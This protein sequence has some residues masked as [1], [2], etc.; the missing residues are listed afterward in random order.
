MSEFNFEA[1]RECLHQF[2]FQELF[3]HQL[4]WE[5]PSKIKTIP[6][7]IDDVTFSSKPISHLSGAAIFEIENP[8]GDIPDK[9]IQKRIHHEVTKFYHENLLVFV[10]GTRTQSSW[11][12]MKTDGNKKIYRDHLYMKGQP[13][14]LF[15]SIVSSMFVDISELDEEGHIPILEASKKIANAFDIEKTTKEFYSEYDAER[16]DL[17]E[18]I[19]GIDDEKDRR[20]YASVLLNRLMFIYFLQKKELINDKDMGYLQN[21][22]AESKERGKNQFYSYFLKLLFFEGFAKPE[23]KRSEE[24]NHV[25]GK[26]RYLNG[27]LFL[28]H[29]LE[30]KWTN[31]CIA[32]DAFENI[33]KLFTRYTWN[34]DDRPGGNDNEISPDVL[35]YIFE[36]YINQKA[37]GAY[38]TKPEITEYLCEHTI[39]QVIL[40]KVN[41]PEIPGVLPARCYATMD[42]MLLKADASLC[43]E[44]LFNVLPKL[45]LLDPA[46]G[47]GA[48][49]VAA[50]KTLINIYSAIIGK[51]DFLGDHQ[52]SNWLQKI[53]SE[54]PSV[55]YF[56]K[57]QIITN[58]LFGVD[59]MPEAAEIAKLRLFL[60]LVASVQTVDQLEPLPNIDFNLLAG[61]SLIGLLRVNEEAFNRKQ[62]PDA[63][64]EQRSFIPQFK[65]VNMFQ[66]SYRQLVDEKQRQL[67][68][69]RNTTKYTE[70]LQ[71]LRDEIESN[72]LQTYESL[73][74]LLLN[75]FSRLEI[76]YEQATWDEKTNK[77]G[78]PVKRAVRLGDIE[79]L[80]PFHWGYE[81][82]EVMNTRGGFDAIITNPPWDIFK[83]NGKEFFLDFSNLIKKKKT[84][85]HD[86][87]KE[88]DQLLENKE[89]R[90]AWLEY[91]SSFPHQ[92]QYYRS[93]EQ[94]TNQISIVD[95]KKTGSDINLYKLFVEQCY[96]LL[97]DGGFCGMVIP[98]GIHT[99][100][101]TLQLRKLLFEHTKVLG[102]FGFENRKAIFEEVHKSFKFDILTYQKSGNTTEF[103]AAF[104]RHEV[105]ELASFPSQ[106]GIMIP[107]D[108]IKLLSPDS[109]SVME[110]KEEI[111][112]LIAEKMLRF[113]LFGDE[114]AGEQYLKLTAEFHMTNDS[115]LFKT[116]P[117]PGRLP[118]YEGKMIWQFNSHYTEPRYWVNE[119]EGRKALLGKTPDN[120]QVLDYQD[121]R[122]GFRDVAASTNERG[123][124]STIISPNNF[125]GNTLIVNSK[126]QFNDDGLL[127]KLLFISG[128]FNS[129]V[130]D[131]LIRQKIT[132]HLSM[133]IIKQM[134]VPRFDP[135]NN[136]QRKIIANTAKLICIS[137]EFN[138]L[139]KAARLSGYQEGVTDPKERA[140]IRAELDA[141]VAHL[142]GL[143]EEEFAHVLITFPIVDQQSKDDTLAAFYA[144]TPD[145]EIATLI[146]RDESEKLEIKS[147]AFI[148]PFTNKPDENM[149]KKVAEA[150]AALMN[151]NGGVLLIG[152]SDDKK[153]LG[154]EHEFAAAN[155]A[156]ADWDGYQLALI[157]VLQTRLSIPHPS[158]YITIAQLQ[159][160]G[161][162]V[163]RIDVQQTPEPVYVEKKLHIRE[164]NRTRELQGPDLVH[165]IHSHWN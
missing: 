116:N 96:N 124:I 147:G 98:S 29:P 110:F 34:L 30:L 164:V 163:C 151:S 111:D 32:D 9:E 121:Y 87:E 27:G 153:I 144:L 130:F 43:R 90:T 93:A 133:Y 148:N 68:I 139:A 122:L 88:M 104:M 127:N 86:F 14:D 159:V 143:S 59:I 1:A 60:A 99:D 152:M 35:G 79:A 157:D 70:D 112:K 118:L 92:S 94:F 61:N 10:N 106:K 120:R 67:D 142:Y 53:K 62:N 100:L 125:A 4:G 113:P 11:L 150:V 76:K 63:K 3:I 126:N 114:I 160:S 42:E 135:I 22:L 84:M 82:D 149:K 40:D 72:R 19:Q 52:L 132:S 28:L 12:W 48:F 13:G 155:P 95:G 36:K 47:S 165:Y 39:Y 49:L 91:E 23:G 2:K 81:F 134:P 6:I 45:S 44:L 140:K 78:K 58:N 31:I 33:F 103:P 129:F 54:H 25:L 77:E 115:H 162:L 138:D 21:K 156:K 69:Y 128:I 108:L 73:N 65:Q 50:M 136:F 8:N 161:L 17:I 20:W 107:V 109:W 89:I 66:K 123:M 117:G 131:W 141:I 16:L 24:A 105:T 145:H 158:H 80:T 64:H 37:F 74:E 26:I 7:V 71:T 5:N 56:I 57:K 101:G 154:I 75:E 83:P 119:K 51:I 18:L 97:R 46:C 55:A 15:L 102:L 41:T 85:I 146:A 137:S 38:Y